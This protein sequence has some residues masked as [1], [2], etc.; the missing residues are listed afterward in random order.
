MVAPF[1]QSISFQLVVA[2]SIVVTLT[3][4][5]HGSRDYY[6]K[7]TELLNFAEENI[8]L[9][10]K[11]L[12]L[13]L[14]LVIWNFE[15]KS[16]EAI[17]QSE[18]VTPFVGAIAVTN[19]EGKTLYQS[20]HFKNPT[21]MSQT[22]ALT[23][24]DEAKI[25]NIGTLVIQ[26][27]NIR[28]SK[29]INAVL[30]NII[31]EAILVNVLLISC[32]LFISR[33]LVRRPLLGISKAMTNIAQGEGDLTQ[34]LRETRQDEVGEISK[35]F[36]SFVTKIQNLMLSM[37]QSIDVLKSTSQIVKSDTE[38]SKVFLEFQ[39]K[40]IKNVSE[41][42]TQMV[43]H[44]KSVTKN[45][46]DTAKTA[47]LTKDKSEQVRDI[48]EHASDSVSHLSAQLVDANKVILDLEMNV[49]EIVGVIEVIRGVAEQTN[50]LALN[51]AIEAAR[52]GE[53]GRGFAVV[54]DEVRALA[55]RTQTS[56]EEI[57][58]MI[59]RLQDGTKSAVTVVQQSQSK[60]EETVAITQQSAKTIGTIVEAATEITSMA[61]E[62]A[63]AVEDQS[64]ISLQLDSSINNIVT[65]ANNSSAVFNEISEQTKKL[66]TL[67]HDINSQ[68]IQFKVN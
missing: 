24:D 11:R 61:K 50:L 67:A 45:A 66:D 30:I 4:L 48:V 53:H 35:Q 6:T 8:S 55:N 41:A 15:S 1:K 32:L 27:D 49:T 25:E 34:R 59:K 26:L 56:T 29:Q 57:D 46:Q 21:V 17:S 5:V 19:T 52:A 20:T 3:M 16:I 51:A 22:F 63:S 10:G 64:Q 36:N 38:Q 18:L 7:K 42:I 68:A 33:A 40:E 12:Q 47:D 13:N 43:E 2:A 28:I 37:N 60:G 14:P 31:L 58:H 65:I 9:T 39:Q 23:Y 44:G 54:A 62:I